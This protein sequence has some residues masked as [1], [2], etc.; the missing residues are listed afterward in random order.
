MEVKGPYSPNGSFYEVKLIRV[1]RD[2]I[3][4]LPSQME[5]KAYHFNNLYQKKFSST[6]SLKELNE[7]NKFLEYLRKKLDLLGKE[8][9]VEIDQELRLPIFKII[10]IETKEVIRQIPLEEILKLMKYFKKLLL[11]DK[12]ELEN[13]KGLILNEEV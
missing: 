4:P 10:D 12:I 9:K 8:L 11:S 13:L 1:S 5:K 3:D 6:S 2:K 7:F